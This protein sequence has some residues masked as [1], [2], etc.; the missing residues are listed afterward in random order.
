MHM[1]TVP[2]Q[3]DNGLIRVS[4]ELTMHQAESLAPLL[5]ASLPTD[6]SVAQLDLSDVSEID[7]AGLQLILSAQRET[8]NRFASLSIVAASQVVRDTLVLFRQ[9]ALLAPPAAT[10]IAAAAKPAR[11]SRKSRVADPS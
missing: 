7:T 11:K 2:V 1:E 6:G 8:V 4:G 9:E 5:L 10:A 3:R